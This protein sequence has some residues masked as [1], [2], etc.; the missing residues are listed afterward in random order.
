[1]LVK[2]MGLIA[3][4]NNNSGFT[5]VEFL[6][7][8]VILMIGLLGMLQGINVAMEKNVENVLRNE[9][10]MVADERM[11]FKRGKQFEALSTITSNI[12]MQRYS[13]GVFKNFSVSEIVSLATPSSKEVRIDVNWK[14]KNIRNTH[15]VSSVV[16]NSSK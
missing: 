14:H 11:M 1:M 2:Q 12:Y 3:M 16:S 4:I 7:A 15:S 13:R 8:I 6:V 10:V 5:L 9:A